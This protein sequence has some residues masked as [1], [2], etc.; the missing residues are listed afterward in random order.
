[1][2]CFPGSM[3]LR[4]A[5]HMRTTGGLMVMAALAFLVAVVSYDPTPLRV[6]VTALCCVL[7]GFFLGRR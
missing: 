3:A 6:A 7:A 4:E 2:A 1:M 5:V